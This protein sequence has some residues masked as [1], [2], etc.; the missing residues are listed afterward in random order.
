MIINRTNTCTDRSDF[1]PKLMAEMETAAPDWLYLNVGHLIKYHKY[2]FRL[3]IGNTQ[4]Y[5]NGYF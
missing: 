1:H 5:D 3:E 4:R 2:T